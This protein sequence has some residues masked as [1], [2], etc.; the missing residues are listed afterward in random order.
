MAKVHLHMETRAR[1]ARRG[2]SDEAVGTPHNQGPVADV[3]IRRPRDDLLATNNPAL[4]R[5]PTGLSKLQV[6]SS[7]HAV[8]CV[9][10]QL[11]GP[12]GDFLSISLTEGGIRLGHPFRLSAGFKLDRR[13][14]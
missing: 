7:V 11:H 14:R 1:E 9:S 5:R 4:G 6:V 10:F 13:W 3:L 8:V 12:A 2:G